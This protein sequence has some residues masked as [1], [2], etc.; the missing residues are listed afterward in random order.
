MSEKE[1]TL[2]PDIDAR[3]AGVWEKL[4]AYVPEDD[5]LKADVGEYLEAGEWGICCEAMAI[6]AKR[7]GQYDAIMPELEPLMIHLIVN[8][9]DDL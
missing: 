4:A 6:L 8:A 9:E 5:P 2:A 1:S 7:Y 3:L